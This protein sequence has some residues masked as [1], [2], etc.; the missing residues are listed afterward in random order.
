MHPLH[1]VKE[2]CN[3]R[4]LQTPTSRFIISNRSLVYT[5]MRYISIRNYVISVISKH[6]SGYA[7]LRSSSP[8]NGQM[9]KWSSVS[10]CPSHWERLT[11]LN[12]H[13]S[14]PSAS[15]FKPSSSPI[16]QYSSILS[17]YNFLQCV[18]ASKR[19]RIS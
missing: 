14:T 4:H 19:V 9:V 10:E 8:S 6:I 18:C 5:V 13:Q 16:A 12:F 1:F 7:L 11:S 17:N 3:K 15:M 2:L